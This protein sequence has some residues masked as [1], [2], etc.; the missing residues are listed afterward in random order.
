LEKKKNEKKKK[1]KKKKKNKK[2]K[3]KTRRTEL[4]LIPFHFYFGP[5]SRCEETA[6][7]FGVGKGRET[8]R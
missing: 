1:K 2:K 7:E 4:Q 3:K 5:D 8:Y 6:E